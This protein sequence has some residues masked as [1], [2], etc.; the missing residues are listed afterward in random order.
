MKEIIMA[1]WLYLGTDL[2]GMPLWEALKKMKEVDFLDGQPSSKDLEGRELV[3]EAFS[4]KYRKEEVLR[5]VGGCRKWQGTV[6]SSIE[7]DSATSW[8]THSGIGRRFVGFIMVPGAGKSGSVEL[9]RGEITD[10]EAVNYAANAFKDLGLLVTVCRDQAGGI[11]L[12]VLAGM[13]NEAA[14]MAQNGIAPVEK[15][16]NMMRLAANFPMGPFEWADKIGL[17]KLLDLLE[18]L[19]KEFGPLYQPCP[20][21]RRKVEA[22]KLGVKKGEGFYNYTEGE[23]K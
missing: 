5:A 15:I 8:A 1:R 20:M 19:T 18:T 2:I 22:G 9:L 3:I 14:M 17:D 12:R 16:D 7:G 11:L 4:E 10:P 13:I 23:A 6:A 21:I